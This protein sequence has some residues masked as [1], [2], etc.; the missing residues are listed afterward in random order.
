MK[1]IYLILALMV[2]GCCY[3]QAS[4]QTSGVKLLDLVALPLLS[5]DSVPSAQDSVY[6][7]MQFKVCNPAGSNAASKAYVLFGTA[8]DSDDILN[9]SADFVYQQGRMLISYDGSLAE[10]EN[11]TAG[12]IIG[13]SAQQNIQCNYIT[14]Y[15]EDSSGYLTQKLYTRN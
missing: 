10:V 14:L 11:Y 4:A 8:P 9:I 7:A 15:I 12:F 1:R 6:I 5:A 3:Q 13:L 2:L